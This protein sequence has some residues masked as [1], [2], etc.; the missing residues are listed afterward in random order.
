LPPFK[1]NSKGKEQADV[2]IRELEATNK[3]QTK[4][5]EAGEKISDK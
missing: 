5:R 4:T 2:M 3:N 1:P